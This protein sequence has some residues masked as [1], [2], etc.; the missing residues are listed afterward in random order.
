MGLFTKEEIAECTRQEL[1]KIYCH[2]LSASWKRFN[3]N[4]IVAKGPGT[5][6][7]V[8]LTANAAPCNASLYDGEDTNGEWIVSLKTTTAQSRPYAFDDH[9]YFR[10]GLY[11]AV[12]ANVLGITIVWHG[13]P[14]GVLKG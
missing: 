6:S 10:R 14:F 5:I 2:A 9:L 11:L 13:F 8:I 1:L 3:A 4:G 7:Y 12:D